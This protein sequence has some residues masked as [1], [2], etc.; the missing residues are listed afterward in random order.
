[1]FTPAQSLH[2]RQRHSSEGRTKTYQDKDED[3]KRV[4]FRCHGVKGAMGSA[5]ITTEHIDKPFLFKTTRCLALIGNFVRSD[6]VWTEWR[7]G[8]LTSHVYEVT[9]HAC[10]PLWA[11]WP[12]L[13]TFSSD[14]A[15]LGYV[16]HQNQRNRARGQGTRHSPPPCTRLRTAVSARR[17][18]CQALCGQ[19]DNST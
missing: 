14:Q 13:N 2:D 10:T 19:E 17:P 15:H 16:A 6:V 12:E 11:D 9:S 8:T 7:G 5:W 4:S 18:G 1:M 3:A